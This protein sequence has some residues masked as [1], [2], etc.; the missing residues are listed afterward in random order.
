M[1]L[2]ADEVV[3]VGLMRKHGVDSK[4]LEKLLDQSVNQAAALIAEYERTGVLPAALAKAFL[5]GINSGT[6]AHTIERNQRAQQIPPLQA[7]VDNQGHG[8]GQ[9]PEHFINDDYLGKGNG[10]QSRLTVIEARKTKAVANLEKVSKVARDCSPGILEGIAS[11]IKDTGRQYAEAFDDLN[12]SV[13]AEVA[14]GLQDLQSSAPGYGDAKTAQPKSAAYPELADAEQPEFMIALLKD[15]ANQ[16]LYL[17]AFVAEVVSAINGAVAKHA[18]LKSVERAVAKV[19]EKYGC[20]FDQLTDIAR[21]TIECADESILLSVIEALKRAMKKG[22]IQ[23]HRIKHRLGKDFDAA[24]AG[25]YRDILLNVTFPPSHHLVELQL[26]L[27]AFVDIKNGGG[28][29]FYAVGRML[30]AFE[31]AATT[32]TGQLTTDRIR[33]V[34]SGLIKKAT[35]VGVE[36]DGHEMEGMMVKA[37]GSRGVQLVELKLLNLTFSGAMQNL[38]WL[39]R[40]A[41]ELASTLQVLQVNEC[42]VNGTIPPEVGELRRLI[43]LNL[44]RNKLEGKL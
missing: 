32:Y 37:L 25:G 20:R 18:P 3:C 12:K 43:E 29:G 26:N 13:M 6:V 22:T 27:K 39:A 30:Q 16:K 28:H 8:K 40:S 34:E 7:L 4:K 5:S 23:V 19:F 41:K 9:T 11:G 31:S 36:G 14:V 24:E 2:S 21:A 10:V 38:N 42:G 15:A 44:V 1:D 35:V 33:D 17:D